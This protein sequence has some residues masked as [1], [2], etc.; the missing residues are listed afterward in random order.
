EHLKMEMEIPCSNKIKFITACSFS[1][2]TFKD[3]DGEKCEHIILN[4][5]SSQDGKRSHDDD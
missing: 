2:D 4:D 3:G 5:T 1:N